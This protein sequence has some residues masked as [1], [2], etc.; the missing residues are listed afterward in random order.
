[1]LIVFGLKYQSIYIKEYEIICS[2]EEKEGLFEEIFED[3]LNTLDSKKKLL[4]KEIEMN[5]KSKK[6]GFFNY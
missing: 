6:T 5:S 2:E 4:N 3:A 1:M